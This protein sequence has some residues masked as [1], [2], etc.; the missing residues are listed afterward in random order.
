MCSCAPRSFSPFNLEAGVFLEPST[1][2]VVPRAAVGYG[3]GRIADPCAEADD[4]LWRIG[5]GAHLL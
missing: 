1:S 5:I 3:Y 4:E 2:I